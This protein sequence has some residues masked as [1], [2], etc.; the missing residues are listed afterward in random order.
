MAQENPYKKAE[1]PYGKDTNQYSAEQ[2]F[3][4]DDDGNFLVDETDNKIIL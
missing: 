1:S 2:A 4:L 3:L